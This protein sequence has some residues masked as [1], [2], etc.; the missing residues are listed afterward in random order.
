MVREIWRRA[1]ETV[2]GV[3]KRGGLERCWWREQMVSA[4]SVWTQPLP[5]TNHVGPLQE[6]GLGKR[7]STGLAPFW[8]LNLGGSRGSS[9]KH[10]RL[11]L[12]SGPKPPLPNPRSQIVPSS[13]SAM[14]N[15][16]EINTVPDT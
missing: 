2:V 9:I 1:G 3:G 13:Q 11:G 8:I 7:E 5:L 12:H 10:M 15:S 6:A 4:G 14:S 16:M